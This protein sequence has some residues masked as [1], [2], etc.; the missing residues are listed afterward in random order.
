MDIHLNT[1]LSQ[2]HQ[3]VVLK[4]LRNPRALSKAEWTIA[5]AAFDILSSC[6][7]A[8]EERSQTFA[9]FYEETFDRPY[10][11]ALIS[12]LLAIDDVESEGALRAEAL[13]KQALAPLQ[14]SDLSEPL[15]EA[16]R[17]LVTYCLYWWGAFAKGYITEIAVFR[18]LAQSG[19]IFQAHDLNQF[20]ERFSP[21]DLIV[22]GMRGDIKSST[23][24]L[25]TARHFPLKHDFYIATL[26]DPQARQRRRVVVMQPDAWDK[27]DGD[28]QA[29]E[30]EQAVTLL[31]Q[32]VAIAVKGQGLIVVDYDLWKD[33]IR[34]LQ[35]RG[36]SNE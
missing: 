15:T 29:A 25:H 1:R 23:Y 28:T 24:F 5:L 26:Y 30:L 7:V 17:L 34:A 9:Q 16:Q 2:K 8:R 12:E 18:D 13:G 22:S 27:I 4:Y 19:I 14:A 31:P 20:A 11:S 21:D 35:K 32:P 33:K 10:A 3:A 36:D 6:R